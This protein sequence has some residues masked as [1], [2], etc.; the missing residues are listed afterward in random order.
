MKILKMALVV[1]SLLI[2]TACSEQTSV[3]NQ[4]NQNMN[5]NN[6]NMN[7]SQPGKISTTFEVVGEIYES[8]ESGSPTYSVVD[9]SRDQRTGCLYT[10]Y[11]GQSPYY[12]SE[13]KVAGCGLTLEEAIEYL[14]AT[15]V[16]IKKNVN[17]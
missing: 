3:Q 4:N 11:Y 6:P 14:N 15:D 8:D 16:N 12:N 7:Q 5:Q 2:V 13:G 17:Q 9:I 10:D 1:I